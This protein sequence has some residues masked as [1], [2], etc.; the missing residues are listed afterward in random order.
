MRKC[1]L[2]QKLMQ[3]YAFIHHKWTFETCILYSNCI[4]FPYKHA[5]AI[6]KCKSY[7]F[8]GFNP[9]KCVIKTLI[10]IHRFCY[11]ANRQAHNIEQQQTVTSSIECHAVHTMR[12]YRYI[13]PTLRL[14]S[15][16]QPKTF[17]R[18]T[19]SR[20]SYDRSTTMFLFCHA[21][22]WNLFIRPHFKQAAMRT[23]HCTTKL[24]ERLF[25]FEWWRWW[26]LSA[27]VKHTT[28]TLE[29]NNEIQANLACVSHCMVS[30][31]DM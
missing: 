28:H 26:W 11:S 19:L 10:R 30:S 31:T 5:Y 24:L 15:Q 9:N 23:Q 29:R 1:S 7:R 6:R 2:Y 20:M 25:G 4:Y 16:S 13:R 8:V 3:V 21:A 17:D 14:T 18:R 27:Q 12:W 22:C